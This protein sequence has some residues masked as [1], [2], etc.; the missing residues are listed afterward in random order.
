MTQGH[1][2]IHT[3]AGVREET[4]VAAPGPGGWRYFGRVRDPES[5]RQIYVVDHIVDLSWRLVRFRLVREGGETL[6][7][8][9]DAGLQ[10][11]T[12]DRTEVLRFD[13]VEVVWSPSPCA[14]HVLDRYLSRSGRTEAEAVQVS[15]DGAA[16]R[17]AIELRRFDPGDRGSVTVDGWRSEV[18]FGADLPRRASDWFDLAGEEVF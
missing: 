7:A 12:A 2:R 14:L 15:A 8:P 10:V 9:S 1:Y 4:F 6:V 3:P 5:G 16:N 13:G 17:V 11:G 18:V